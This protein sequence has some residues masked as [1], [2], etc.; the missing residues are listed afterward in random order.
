[1]NDFA[2]IPYASRSP[3][4]GADAGYLMAIAI[5]ADTLSVVIH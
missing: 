4:D 2:S 5:G 1:L 3:I